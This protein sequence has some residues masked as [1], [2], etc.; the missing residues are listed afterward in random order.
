MGILQR[1][2][3]L[4]ARYSQPHNERGAIGLVDGVIAI[5]A[6]L[7]AVIALAAYTNVAGHGRNTAVTMPELDAAQNATTD[8]RALTEYNACPQSTSICVGNSAAT[9]GQVVIAD[10]APSAKPTPFPGA[11]AKRLAVPAIPEAS[12]P[13][14][15]SGM[16]FSTTTRV[17]TGTVTTAKT[18]TPLTVGQGTAGDD[19]CPA[20]LKSAGA[21]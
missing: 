21:C 7:A 8:L 12:T 11:V 16:N 10:P 20:S 2:S 18:T 19:D 4:S 15:L 5:V 9:A 1:R 14:T 6:I 13:V 17:I 3:S